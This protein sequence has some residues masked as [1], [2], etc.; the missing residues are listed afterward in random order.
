MLLGP[1]NMLFTAKI[2]KKVRTPLSPC[3]T[4]GE[5][6]FF[7]KKACTCITKGADTFKALCHK[8]LSAIFLKKACT[9]F[10]DWKAWAQNHAI[11]TRNG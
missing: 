4:K 6:D 7:A 8:R 11:F 9:Y 5:G 10:L 1:E 2:V 3:R